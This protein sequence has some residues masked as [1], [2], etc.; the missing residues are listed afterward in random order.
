MK[1]PGMKPRP[2]PIHRPPIASATTPSTM[3]IQLVDRDCIDGLPLSMRCMSTRG[4]LVGLVIG[5]G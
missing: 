4:Y 1:L 3:D 2:W 5:S